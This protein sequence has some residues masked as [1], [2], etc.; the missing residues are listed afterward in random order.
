MN[1][2]KPK[3]SAGLLMYK[4]VDSVPYYFLVHPAG[5]FW[6]NK[7]LGAWSIPKGE[8]EEGENKLE[9]A[10]REFIEETG[11]KPEE[12]F[13]E[14]GSIKQKGGKTV[15]AWGFKGDYLGNL[16]CTSYVEIEWPSKSGKYINF[17]EVDKGQ[18]FYKD[19]ANK[20][21]NIMQVEFIERLE[22]Q[23]GLYK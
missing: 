20:Y 14:L 15:Y 3:Q 11:I 8:F 22:K 23:L 13:I 12:P 5:P 18:L 4:F 19:E 17:P 2:S 1:K 7:E 10:I 21:M 6:K 9:C 16:N